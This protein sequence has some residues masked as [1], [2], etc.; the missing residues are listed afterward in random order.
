LRRNSSHIGAVPHSS[1]TGCLNH[2]KFQNIP[3]YSKRPIPREL[4]KIA[5]IRH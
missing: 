3:D 4:E 2:S 1:P 5:L